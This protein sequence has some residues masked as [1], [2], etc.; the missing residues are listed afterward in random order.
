[1]ASIA[2]GKQAGKTPLSRKGSRHASPEVRRAQLLEAAIRC[3][4]EQGYYGTTMDAVA[5]EAG[6]SKGSLYRFFDS[7][8]ALLMAIL[9][10]WAAGARERWARRETDPNPLLQLREYGQALVDQMATHRALVPLWLEFFQHEEPRKHMREMYASARKRLAAGIRAGVRSGQLRDVAPTQ[11]AD[12]I[13]AVLEG[14]SI[15]AAVDPGFDIQRRFAGAWAVLEAGL[16]GD[17]TG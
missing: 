6:L 4:S 2:Q 13:M 15:M 9:D 12:A 3:F 16:V 14:I 7:K 1:M 10:E 5:E 8:D 17:Q 11:A